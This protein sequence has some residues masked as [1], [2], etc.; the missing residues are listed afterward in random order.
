M[1]RPR[2]LFITGTDTGV[3]K[4]LIAAGLA[5][6]CRAQGMDVGV[7]KPVATGGIRWRRPRGR[8]RWLSPDAV[9]LARA[10]DVHDPWDL[11]NPECFREPLA[12]FV[13]AQRAG[14]AVRW[15]AILRAYRRLQQRHPFLIIEGIGGLLVP[16]SRRQTVADLIQAF[17]LPVLIV[18]RRRL[19]TLNH[20]LLTVREAQRQ[21]L[22][23]HGVILNAADPPTRDAGLR[24]AERTNPGALEGWLSISL[25]GK[26]PY[27]PALVYPPTNRATIGGGASGMTTDVRWRHRLVNWV[28]R[29]CS[30]TL[31]KWLLTSTVR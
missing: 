16:L 30:P 10:A 19:G 4:T 12:P 25:L 26:T 23:V 20:T 28:E 9:L 29:S 1:R 31:L 27:D 15:P 14:K 21:G 17:D 24:L 7:M 8:S 11:I 13:A 22:R 5:A 18:A 2:G 3:G 6:W